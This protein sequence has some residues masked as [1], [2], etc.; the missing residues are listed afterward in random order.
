MPN[1][2]GSLLMDNG[3]QNYDSEM[4][5]VTPTSSMC[6]DFVASNVGDKLSNCI[7]TS[8]SLSNHKGL[9][10]GYGTTTRTKSVPYTRCVV[11]YRCSQWD[12][13]NHDLGEIDRNV[14]LNDPEVDTNVKTWTKTL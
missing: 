1:R 3:L 9:I 5:H 4:I 14:M 8:P 7:L 13:I 10:C 12:I 2:F 11:N 6:I